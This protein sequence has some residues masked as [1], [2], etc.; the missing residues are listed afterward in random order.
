MMTRIKNVPMNS[1]N[2]QQKKP[3]QSNTIILHP[4]PPF[5]SLPHPAY[6][7]NMGPPTKQRASFPSAQAA[8]TPEPSEALTDPAQQDQGGEPLP[9]AENGL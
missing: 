8:E 6:R 5:I 2:S 4:P 1:I 9:G 7:E 3:A